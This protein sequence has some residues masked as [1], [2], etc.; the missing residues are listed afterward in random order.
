MKSSFRKLNLRKQVKN[1]H[2]VKCVVSQAQGAS[3]GE[4][5]QNNLAAGS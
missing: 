4:P 5:W 1:D 2:E 3:E